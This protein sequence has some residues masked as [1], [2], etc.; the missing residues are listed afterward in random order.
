MFKEGQGKFMQNRIFAA[1][2]AM[3]LVAAACGGGEPASTDTSADVVTTSAVTTPGATDNTAA[4]VAATTT[5][6]TEAPVEES[7]TTTEAAPDPSIEAAL[8][9]AG[10]YTG[11]WTN[12]TF[13]STGDAGMTM[14]VSEA[15]DVT[16][17]WDL[18]GGVFGVG[19]PD[20]ENQTLNVADMV[21]GRTVT[22]ALF[23]DMGVTV[24]ADFVTIT[25]DAE[26]VP[27][28][29]IQAFRATATWSD[30]GTIAGIYVVEFDG[31]GAPAEGT[32]EMTR[33]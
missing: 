26:N 3:I 13:G 18:G 25:L 6:T 19:D 11:S 23:G 4:S 7:T 29:G 5:T 27:T 1:G 28:S 33:G 31:G 21:G 10:T 20:G 8:A 22:T 30:D 12:T 32:F 9:A 24:S 16:M 15:G 2:A 17:E 14:T